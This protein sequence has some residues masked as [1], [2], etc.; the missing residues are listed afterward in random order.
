MYETQ[1]CLFC[2]NILRNYFSTFVCEKWSDGKTFDAVIGLH[3]LSNKK[4][5]IK[6]LKRKYFQF[7]FFWSHSL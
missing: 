1:K 2:W 3:S 5:K 6:K 4:Q 7:F